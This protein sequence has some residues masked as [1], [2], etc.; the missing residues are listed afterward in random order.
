MVVLKDEQIEIFI[1]G[2]HPKNYLKANNRGSNSFLTRNA[3][4]NL[5]SETILCNKRQKQIIIKHLF[6][7]T[8]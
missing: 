3:F 1:L 5:K 6:I 8:A 2:K 7:Y 4:T